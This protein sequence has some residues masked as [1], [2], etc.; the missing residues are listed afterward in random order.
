[1]RKFTSALMIVG[2]M[3][4]IALAGLMILPVGV[5]LPES[6]FGAI[7]IVFFAAGGVWLIYKGIRRSMRPTGRI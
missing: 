3:A 2:G 1:M 7:L 4:A 5:N 6:A